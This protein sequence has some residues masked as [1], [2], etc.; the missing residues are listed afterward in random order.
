MSKTG[1]LHSLSTV[2]LRQAG[3][4]PWLDNI[5]RELLKSGKLKELVEDHGLL[6]VTS[7]PSIFEKSITQKDGGYDRDILKFVRKGFSTLQIYDELT[8]SDIQS[9]CDFFRKVHQSSKGEHGYVSLEVLPTLAYE[10]ERSVSEAIRLFKAVSRP[11]VMI[12]VPATPEGVRAVRC[13]IGNGININVT[14]MFSRKHYRD[15]A[16]AYIDGLADFKRKGGDPSRVHSVASVFVSRIDSWIDKKLDERIKTAGAG[17][18]GKLEALKGRAAVANSKLIYQDFKEIFASDK[19]KKLQSA[20][21]FHQKVLWGSTSTKNPDYPDLLYVEPLIGRET[22]NTMPTA[23]L[24]A[25]MDHGKVYVDSIEE[26]VDAARRTVSE[27]ESFGFL[28]EELGEQDR[29][30]VV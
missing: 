10:E 28:F 4:S 20:G 12:K 1:L 18:K 19:F 11:N 27:I 29:K 24:E 8:L 3:Q 9:A 30:S 14:L 5:S 7:N 13:L 2:E 16:N 23:T 15:V 17:E 25:F 22:V 21:A 6:G 26:G